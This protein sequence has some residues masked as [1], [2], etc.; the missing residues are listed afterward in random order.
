MGRFLGY[1]R[2]AALRYS[3]L[4]A[5]PAVFGS[6]FYEL[7]G[8]IGSDATDQAFSL[9]E[10]MVATVAAFVIGYAVIAWLLKFVMTKSFAPFIYYRIG[11]G[12]L[13]LVGLTTGVIG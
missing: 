2:E 10:T 5:L 13:I 4:L 3:F 12:A 1:S 6:G 8:A 11:L 9:L 7:K